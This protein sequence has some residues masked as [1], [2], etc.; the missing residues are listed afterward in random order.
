MFLLLFTLFLA[1]LFY[2][3]L[4]KFIL[5]VYRTTQQV[6]R[7]FR[8][9]QEQMHQSSPQQEQ[10]HTRP[11]RAQGEKSAASDYIDFEEVK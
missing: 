3:L 10:Y 6:K 4:V 8:D 11:K 2:Q 9:M 7:S 5:P 1:Y